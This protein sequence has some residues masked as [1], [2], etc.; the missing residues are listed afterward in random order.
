MRSLDAAKAPKNVTSGSN[1]AGDKKA[2]QDSVAFPFRRAVLGL[3][4]VVVC[5]GIPYLFLD[6]ASAGTDPIS[7]FKPL[8]GQVSTGN[9][10][11]MY[12]SMGQLSA[13]TERKTSAML[14]GAGV[15]LTVSFWHTL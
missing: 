12:Y 3:L 15:G 14:Y 6:N 13:A 11:Q 5:W 2:R 10:A 9:D 4:S 1:I 8:E 7:R